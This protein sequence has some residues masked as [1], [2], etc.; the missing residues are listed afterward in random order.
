MTKEELRSYTTIKAELAELNRLS[1]KVNRE[2][3]PEAAALYDERRK[4]L[5]DKLNRFELA[6]ESLESVERRLL[7][8]RYVLNLEWYQVAA[9]INYSLQQTHRIHA[10]A[11]IKLKDK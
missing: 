2:A 4:K 1:E 3:A 10:R 7:R 9:R 11:L 8:L 6:I 5:T